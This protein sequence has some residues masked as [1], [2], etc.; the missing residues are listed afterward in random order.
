M[1]T[2]MYIQLPES[3]DKQAVGRAILQGAQ[4]AE[5]SDSTSSI[6]LNEEVSPW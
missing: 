1:C 3:K 6:W 2:N 5:N 4:Q